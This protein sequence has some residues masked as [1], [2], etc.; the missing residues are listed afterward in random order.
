MSNPQRGGEPLKLDGNALGKLSFEW[1]TDRYQHKWLFPTPGTPVVI[2]SA[3]SGSTAIWPI[4]PP[5]QQIHQQSFADGRTVVFGVGMAGRGHW[6]ASF[7]LVPDLKC[8]IVELACRSPMKPESLVSTYQLD[9]SWKMSSPGRF[10]RAT[11]DYR[12]E[13]EAISP[14]AE[15]TMHEDLVQ[16]KPAR[17][18]GEASTTQWAFRVRAG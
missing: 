8:W 10:I 4:S 12:L 16:I 7:T 11:D 14:S 18:V 15:A 17:I 5:L 1:L 6:S 13:I 3:E 2:A 9:A